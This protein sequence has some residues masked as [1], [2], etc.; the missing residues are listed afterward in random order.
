MMRYWSNSKLVKRDIKMAAGTNITAIN[1]PESGDTNYVQKIIDS[2]TA[3]DNHDHSANKG[4]PIAR[5]A[6]LAVTTASLADLAVTAGK[7]AADAVTTVKIL[8]LNVTTGKIANLGVTTGKLADGAVTQAKR[9]ALG[10]VITGL[11][12]GNFLTTITSDVTNVSETIV[13]TG[14]LVFIG[15]IPF[16]SNGGQIG[17]IKNSTTSNYGIFSIKRDGAVIYSTKIGVAGATAG[18]DLS[19]PPSTIWFVD[20]VSAGSHEYKLSAEPLAGSTMYAINCGMVL[21]EL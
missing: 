8:D 1:S 11:S 7:I 17:V 19:L 12:S 10:Q 13:T 5:I 2:F 16:D 4:L 15:I 14:R 18:L 3:V 6:N 21:Y 20:I 9:A